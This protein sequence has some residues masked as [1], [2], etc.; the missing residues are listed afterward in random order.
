MAAWCADRRPDLDTIAVDH[1]NIHEQVEWRRGF[2]W[3]EPKC[4]ECR[5]KVVR[6][7][8]VIVATAEQL[9][10]PAVAGSKQGIVNA[11]RGILDQRQDRP[12][13][14]GD[15]RV[16]YRRDDPPDRDA[17]VLHRHELMQVP[18]IE[19]PGVDD[20]LALGVDD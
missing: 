14:I 6:A 11:A 4:F 8:V 7:V 18:G 12:P 15:K 9:V 5:A 3:F 17:A 2:R 1:R 20:L 16:A 19:G 10:A 13:L